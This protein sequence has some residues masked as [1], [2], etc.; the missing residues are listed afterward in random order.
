[1]SS[2][3]PERVLDTVPRCVRWPL[4]KRNYIRLPCRY[5]EHIIHD[6]LDLLQ[7]LLQTFRQE[8]HVKLQA[9]AIV[10]KGCTSGFIIIQRTRA[11]K[12]ARQKPM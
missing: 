7:A 4:G 6:S 8:N 9:V 5:Q 10:E 3:P 1:M 2:M 11:S 12:L